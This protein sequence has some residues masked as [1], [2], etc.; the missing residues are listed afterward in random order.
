[1]KNS[2][3]VSKHREFV[4]NAR[5]EMMAEY[6]ITILSRGENH[7]VVSPGEVV[8]K[9]GT[10][11]FRL[12]VNMRYVNR[13]LGPKHFEF[14]GLKDLADLAEG[15]PRDDIRP[16]VGMLPRGSSSEVAD[17]RRAQ[18]GRAVLRVQLHALRA[19]DKPLDLLQG[20]AGVG[21]AMEE[22]RH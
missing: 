3:S 17:L 19:F 22:G 2:P 10:N 13:Q 11:K 9:N 12:T 6:A 14:E 8:Q 16:N 7:W 20:N 21:D 18:A 1:M 15:G 4:S 5:A